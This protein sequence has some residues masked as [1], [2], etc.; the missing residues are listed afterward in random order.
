MLQLG[1]RV[2]GPHVFLAAD[3]EGVLAA[4]IEHGRQ[5]RVG[6]ESLVVQADRLFGDLEDADA[7]DV[8]RRTG[9][10]LLDELL[11]QADGLED[12]RPGVGHVGRN[13]HL[14]HDLAQALADRLDEVLGVLLCLPGITLGQSL[15]G[16]EG[17][18]GVYR[19]GA[20]AAEQ[21]EVMHL[22]GR[23]G[24]DD[25]AGAGAQ[26]LLDQ[27]LV[28]RRRRQ[29]RRDRDMLGIDLAVGNDQ[30]IGARAY[31]VFGIR[32][33][34][35]QTRLDS[36]LAPGNG[37]ADIEFEGAELVRR[38]FADVAQLFHV[39]EGQD[40]LRDFEADR[41]VDVVRV[42]QVRLRPDE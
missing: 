9:E 40:R 10:V 15:D 17:Q 32:S 31:R 42:Q 14:G 34:R 26:A 35:S 2:R 27:V 36:V 38:V 33:Q 22:T 3:A 23:A 8:G 21:G 20:V 41:R 19:F 4:G 25:E 13:A 37:V 24:L 16:F 6:R 5:H 29:Q 18:V 11:L 28:D 12:L 7:L 39:G 1:D 30:D